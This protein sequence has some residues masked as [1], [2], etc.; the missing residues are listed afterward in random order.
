MFAGTKELPQG[1]EEV[2]SNRVAIEAGSGFHSNSEG[3][4]SQVGPAFDFALTGTG[5]LLT[6]STLNK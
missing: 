3:F 5:R 4:V 6:R 2:L 1:D